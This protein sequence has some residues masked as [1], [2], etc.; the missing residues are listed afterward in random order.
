MRQ[1]QGHQQA[2]RP[3]MGAW[4]SYGLGSESQNLPGF[5]VLV[6]NG[7]G[8]QPLISRLFLLIFPNR[9]R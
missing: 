4:L 2:G 6:T 1:Q 7:Q 8:G 9:C 5:V 3:S